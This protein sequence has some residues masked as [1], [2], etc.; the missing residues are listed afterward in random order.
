LW[1]T[2]NKTWFSSPPG[3]YCEIERLD[4]TTGIERR[5][6]I[7]SDNLWN[8]PYSI[9]D[10]LYL[11]S[12]L[13][14]NLIDDTVEGATTVKIGMIDDKNLIR[15]GVFRG[16]PQTNPAGMF[17]YEGKLTAI[18]IDG[19]NRMRL[20]HLVDGDWIDGQEILL[21][22]RGQYWFDET[23]PRPSQTLAT[24]SESSDDH[25]EFM[26]LEYLRVSQTGDQCRLFLKTTDDQG[27][28]RFVYRD[29]FEFADE[30]SDV[31]SALL[32]T[33]FVSDASG[34]KSWTKKI[35][36]TFVTMESDAA[37]SLICLNGVDNFWQK[38]CVQ[39]NRLVADGNC[40]EITGLN[41]S[42]R[43]SLIVDSST[44][45]AY[46]VE[47]PDDG[48]NSVAFRRINGDTIEPAFLVLN[49]GAT[50]FVARWR[51][52]FFGSI[53]AWIAHFILMTSATGCLAVN[54]SEANYEVD[55][56]QCTIAP[57]WRRLAAST[58]DLSLF[59]AAL[60]VL[61]HMF[62][63]IFGI[64]WS[65]VDDNQLG[66]FLFA[67]QYNSWQGTR[68]AQPFGTNSPD[69][70]SVVFSNWTMR[71]IRHSVFYGCWLGSVIVLIC[72]RLF[73]EGRYGITPGKWLLGIRTVNSYFGRTTLATS[74]I[75]SLFCL[76]DF[77]LFYTP[78]PAAI[79]MILSKHRRRMGDFFA[80]TT[81]IKA[82]SIRDIEWQKTE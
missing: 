45:V 41:P 44:G 32:P 49:G 54:V 69:P 15:K 3:Q 34:W 74:V 58:V 78:I 43:N 66:D 59:L 40:R 67:V 68:W 13:N 50:Q 63:F 14:I 82:G 35:K 28:Q 16:P 48:W 57:V 18:H 12:A 5:T 75:R 36:G 4:L 64:A 65:P 2:S 51:F 17:L 9:G 1:F 62:N 37:G 27:Q 52:W 25:E 81:V 8:V 6:R 33:N 11:T 72:A 77:F 53:F 38:I 76:I 42:V 26:G 23:E 73:F 10:Q 29:G 79:F 47:E 56:Q 71:L 55:L 60:F 31:A 7:G 39:I 46:V 22:R 19:E 20:S 24:D 21:P 30:S 70:F 80:N 61:W